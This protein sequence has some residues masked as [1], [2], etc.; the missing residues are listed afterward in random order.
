MRGT[1][2]GSG[3]GDRADRRMVDTISA[4]ARLGGRIA[5]KHFGSPGLRVTGKGDPGDLVSNADL[6]IEEAVARVLARGFPGVPVV[7]EEGGG[8]AVRDEAFYVDPI[9][10][11]LNFVHGLLPFAVSIG[12]WRGGAPVAGAVYDPVSGD[13]FTA[14]QGA[15]AWLNGRPIRVSGAAR[16]R[17]SLVAGG[18]PY[19]REERARL[20]SQME[21]VYM[22]A[23]ELR[24]IGCASLGLCRVACGVFDA[25]WEWGLKPWDLAAGVLLVSEA[26]GRVS[27][28]DGG[29]F[30]LEEGNAAASNGLVHDELV[31][32]VTG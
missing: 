12:Y 17:D 29:A 5:L 23:Q 13:L 20:L 21:R 22:G 2:A 16:L 28:L 27:A 18:W 1:G 24:T 15:G 11:T 3:A 31:R 30:R 8:A 25:Y 19:A 4:A 32:A 7:G 10:G 26:G 6:E 14:R 9:D